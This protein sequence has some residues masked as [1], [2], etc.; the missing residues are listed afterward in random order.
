M[1]TETKIVSLAILVTLLLVVVVI[2]NQKT[3]VIQVDTQQYTLKTRSFTVEGALHAAGIRIRAGDQVVPDLDTWLKNNTHISIIHPLEVKIIAD[4]N[5]QNLVTPERLPRKI[6]AQVGLQLEIGDQLLYDGDSISVG[7][8]IPTTTISATLEIVRAVQIT[9]VDGE[10]SQVI[11]S[12]APTLGQALEDSGIKLLP[13]DRLQPEAST[14]LT[15]SLR[16]NVIHGRSLFIHA[17]GKVLEITSA[18]ETVGQALADAGLSLLDNDICIPPLENQIPAD[19]QIT[20]TRVTVVMTQTKETIPF[21]TLYQLTADLEIDSSQVLQKGVAGERVHERRIRSED[22]VKVSDQTVDYVAVEP[23]NQII[24]F[25]TKIV[26]RTSSTSFGKI[27]YWRKVDVY[28]TSYSPCNSGVPGKCYDLTASGQP[29][30][31]G[32]VGVVRSWYDAMLGSRIY[33]PGYGNAVIADI[34]GGIPGQ[35]WIDLG[36]SDKDYIGW[37][38]NVTIYF[39][40]PI[41]PANQILWILP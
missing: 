16:V 12:V 34:G 29:V 36:Y 4:T 24:G 27:E 35:Y 30:Q 41:P 33:V 1:K 28:A 32:V 2:L 38:Q 10:S 21:T 13:T 23:K 18:R 14:P 17:D 40:T 7:Q 26:V 37:H 39:L 20:I 31:Q 15:G 11:Y 8:I 6:L 25:G 19:G 9:L 5:S 22:G 3:I